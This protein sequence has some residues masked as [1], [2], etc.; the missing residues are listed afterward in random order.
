[1]TFYVSID[2]LKH[3]Y[4]HKDILI[5]VYQATR[6]SIGILKP[7]NSKM[8]EVVSSGWYE[9]PYCLSTLFDIAEKLAESTIVGSLIAVGHPDINKIYDS[10]TSTPHRITR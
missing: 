6:H 10:S 3:S 8:A 7:I 2:D 5:D 9:E 4:Y 1:M